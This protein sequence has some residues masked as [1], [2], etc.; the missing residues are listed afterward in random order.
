MPVSLAVLVFRTLVRFFKFS[1]EFVKNIPLFVR[2][3][4]ILSI[5]DRVVYF[6]TSTA[7]WEKLVIC[8]SVPATEPVILGDTFLSD[9]ED[10]LKQ[11]KSM[12]QAL[13][14]PMQRFPVKKPNGKLIPK[15]A[16]VVVQTGKMINRIRKYKSVVSK[17]K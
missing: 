12:A 11:I 9:F 7:S 15:A 16:N 3:A 5:V 2:A 6:A 1:G 17:S 8:T 14:I 10:L 13:T 4:F